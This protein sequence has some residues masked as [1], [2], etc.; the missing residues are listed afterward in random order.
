MNISFETLR[1]PTFLQLEAFAKL[2]QMYLKSVEDEDS[3]DS[4]DRKFFFYTYLSKFQIFTFKNIILTL[5]GSYSYQ[6]CSEIGGFYGYNKTVSF[7]I[8]SYL[9]PIED[10]LKEKCEPFFGPK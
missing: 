10:D 8:L 3:D 6:L 5:S 4:A 7:S 9:S 1:V 2:R